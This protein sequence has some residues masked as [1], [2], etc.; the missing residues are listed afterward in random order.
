MKDKRAYK[1][2][3]EII[4]NRENIVLKDI[5][6]E[7]VV[8]NEQGKRA[9]RLDAWALDEEDIQYAIEM[10]ND[11]TTD[12]IPKRSRYYQGILDAP[13]LKSGKKTKYKHLPKTYIIFTPI[14]ML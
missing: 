12:F 6:V 14:C 13:I 5:K 10:Q 11:T 2:V 9:I 3:L 4:M 7:K 1:N 8:L